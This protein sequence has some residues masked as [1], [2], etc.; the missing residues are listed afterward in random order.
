MSLARSVQKFT[1]DTSCT[2]L[3]AISIQTMLI[4]EKQ[5]ILQAPELLIM[6]IQSSL[7]FTNLSQRT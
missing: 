1:L 6:D 5:G 2:S 7:D 3:I 4:I